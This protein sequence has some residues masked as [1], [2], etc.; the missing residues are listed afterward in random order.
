MHVPKFSGK[1]CFLREGHTKRRINKVTKEYKIIKKK[2]RV[3]SI[4]KPTKYQFCV[5]AYN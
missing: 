1:S 3:K 4:T 2:K 5:A